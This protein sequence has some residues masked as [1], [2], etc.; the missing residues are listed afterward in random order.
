MP[1]A[2][3]NADDLVTGIYLASAA[4]INGFRP[5]QPFYLTA[6]SFPFLSLQ[7]VLP[8]GLGPPIPVSVSS[9]TFYRLSSSYISS[10]TTPSPIS[11]IRGVQVNSELLFPQTPPHA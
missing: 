7:P 3:L 6:L 8:S 10:F 1:S 2:V 11:E 5:G 9:V 4:H